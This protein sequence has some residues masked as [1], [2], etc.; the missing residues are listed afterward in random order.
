MIFS[1]DPILIETFLNLQI[2]EI[3]KNYLLVPSFYKIDSLIFT[4]IC[5][6]GSTWLIFTKSSMCS[7]EEHISTNYWADL[8][9][10]MCGAHCFMGISSPKWKWKSNQ[11]SYLSL[12]R[13]FA[14]PWTIE[15][16]EFSRPE[17]WSGYF[18]FSRRS[19]WPRNRTRVSCIAGGFFTNHEGSLF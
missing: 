13:L 14:T 15:S 9:V 1:F 17:Y 10:S 12:V 3:K 18:P 7:W 8:W 4:G 19:S 5:F 6:M 16:M 2:Y 11:K